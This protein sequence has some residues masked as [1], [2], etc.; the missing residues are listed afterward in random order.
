[1]ERF[2]AVNLQKPSDNPDYSGIV[3]AIAADD[4]ARIEFLRVCL[5]KL[6]LEVNEEEQAVPSLSRTHLSSH[7]A[8]DIAELVA[9]WHEIITLIDGDEYIKGENDT[10]QLE[11][12]EA[13]SIS[14]LT[15]AV[16]NIVP[17]FD[18]NGSALEET[19]DGIYDFNKVI[20]K[21]IAHE[22]DLPSN[23]ETPNFNH[24]AFFSNLKQFQSST[25]LFSS[26]QAD[27]EFG[28]HLL[29]GEVVTSTNTLLEKNP[30]LLNHLPNGTTFT[31]T[32]QIAGRG[33]GT[34][35]WVSPAGSLIFSTVIRHSLTLSA[36]AP[37]VFVQYLAALA[38][39]R[40]IKTYEPG[41]S[42]LPVKLKWPNDVYALDPADKVGKNVVK[43]GGILVNSS[44][45]GNSYTMV[46]G[47]GINVANQACPTTTLNKLAE[48]AGLRPFQ[49]E[50]LLA[51]I[52]IAF[53]DV[54][55]TFCR[56]GFDREL[57]AEYYR[58]WLHT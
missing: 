44:Y 30:N 29:Y 39:V 53:E 46:A 5:R 18:G 42:K 56:T 4:K 33:R 10:F 24:H 49:M 35:V 40:G 52:L 3:E 38:I 22:N 2:A 9:S 41:Y 1:M 54:Y 6:G 8:S 45:S 21:V 17:S 19:A 34:N 43:I 48:K 26:G 14:A 13:W 55:K 50:K 58:S 57:E 31:A 32:T 23:K 51:S 37:V 20:K 28:T 27:P 12:P 11:K 36:S 25:K 16:K 15:D 47:V 7:R